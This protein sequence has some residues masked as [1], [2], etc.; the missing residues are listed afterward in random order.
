MYAIDDDVVGA[1]EL[2]GMY[3]VD[4]DDVVSADELD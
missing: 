3:T 4:D 1:D 2:E